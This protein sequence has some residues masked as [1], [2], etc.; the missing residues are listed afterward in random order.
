MSAD[1]QSEFEALQAEIAHDEQTLLELEQEVSELHTELAA[2]KE[3]YDRMVGPMAHRMQVVKEA[4]L[5]LEAELMARARQTLQRGNH[6]ERVFPEGYV[7]VEEQHR[8]NW[9]KDNNAAEEAYTP[10]QVRLPD[11]DIPPEPEHTDI[12][13]LYRQ[14]ARRYHPDFTTNDDDR[15]FRTAVMAQINAAY[16]AHDYDALEALF[17]QADDL[18][19]SGFKAGDS[20]HLLKLR[21]LQQIRDELRRRIYDLKQQKHQLLHCDLM[22][23]KIEEKLVS[24]SGRDLFAEMIA[25]LDLSYRALLRRLYNL[26]HQ[27]L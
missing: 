6:S 26:R 19:G 23:L 12:K 18:Q 15:K 17:A 11:T 27:V 10:P 13:Q 8:R 5:E 21:Q 14:L 16:A 20:L 24:A 2:F 22:V 1:S 3:K 7:P 25:D 9:K 4:I